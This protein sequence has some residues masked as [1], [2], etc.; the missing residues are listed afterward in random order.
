VVSVC[1]SQVGVL[2]KQQNAGSRKQRQTI[3]QGVSFS[4]AKDL[5]KTQTESPPTEAPNVGGVRLNWRLSINLAIT[6]KR[7]Q[8]SSVASLSHCASTFVCSRFACCS[9]V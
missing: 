9:I 4:D 5:G 8:L 1:L 6:R 2:L 3:A 7:C